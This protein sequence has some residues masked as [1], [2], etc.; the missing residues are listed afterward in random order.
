MWGEEHK[1]KLILSAKDFGIHKAKSLPIVMEKGEK[2]NVKIVGP[3][4]IKGEKL[5][6]ARDRCVSILD[7]QKESGQ[8]KAKIVSNKHN[9]YVAVLK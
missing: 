5:G 8:V 1:V 3:G 2:V 9:I 7:C 4:W 6:I